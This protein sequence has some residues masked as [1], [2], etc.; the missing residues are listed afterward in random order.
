MTDSMR[1]IVDTDAGVDDAQALMLALAFPGARVEAITAVTGNVHVD[2]VC[3]NIASLLDVMETDVPFYRGAELPLLAE[4]EAEDPIVHGTDGMGD[5]PERAHSARMPEAEHA[6]LALLRLVS[7]SPG[8]YTLI[9]LGPL[10]NIALAVRLDPTFPQKVGRW[11][12]MGGSIEGRGNTRY[13]AAEWNIFCDPEAA[14]VAFS[15]MPHFTLV[16]WEAT[17][18]NP[19]PL[20]DYDR[21]AALN[22]PR[23]RFF[24][25]IT[26]STRDFA[27]AVRGAHDFMI[28][29]PLAMAVALDPSLITDSYDAYTEV[30]LGGRLARGMTVI[31]HDSKLGKPD[32]ATVVTRIDMAGV[33]ALYERALAG[34]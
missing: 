10:T 17:I 28:P 8:A 23:G 11:V 34:K 6:V 7:E 3:R 26:E 5:W 27:D 22:T 16:S 9:T 14:F 32:N 15:T 25:G 19:L 24:R 30:E 2:L 1:L 21:L 18:H 33:T 29:D 13:P 31:D 20:P 4:W 12:C